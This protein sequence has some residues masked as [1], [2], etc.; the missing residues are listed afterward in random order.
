MR[1]VLA[2]TSAMIFVALSVSLLLFYF[3]FG[4]GD[5]F[6]M[7]VTLAMAVATRFSLVIFMRIKD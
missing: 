4:R 5:I 7:A 6:D 2:F 3:S 1:A